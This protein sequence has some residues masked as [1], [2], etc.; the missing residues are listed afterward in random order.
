[1]MSGWGTLT[2]EASYYYSS[3]A[4][5]ND[6]QRRLGP[7]NWFGYSNPEMDRLIQASEFELDD[8]KRRELLQQ[9]GALFNRERVALPLASVNSAWALRRDRVSMAAGRADE[10]TYAWDVTPAAAR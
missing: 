3:N 4:H 2:G 6:A 7:F 10:E 9:I 1:M 8:N 5:T